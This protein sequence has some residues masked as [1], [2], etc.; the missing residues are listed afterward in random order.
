MKTILVTGGCGFIGSNFIRYV[1]EKNEDVQIVNLDKLTYAGNIK[2]LDGL[3]S[4]K[5]QL[6][7]ND[8]CD[9]DIVDSLF[10]KFELIQ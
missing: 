6:V 5:Y 8:I 10:E 2:N 1:I 4:K 9:Y 7:K 3:P